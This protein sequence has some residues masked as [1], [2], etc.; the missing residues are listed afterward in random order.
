MCSRYSSYFAPPVRPGFSTWRV[1]G[2]K[3]TPT[4]PLPRLALP[5]WLQ[6][7]GWDQHDPRRTRVRQHPQRRLPPEKAGRHQPPAVHVGRRE[8]GA[9]PAPAQESLPDVEWVVAVVGQQEWVVQA[10]PGAARGKKTET[11]HHASRRHTKHTCKRA[12]ALFFVGSGEEAGQARDAF[13]Q[14]CARSRSTG[15]W[16]NPSFSSTRDRP[17]LEADGRVGEGGAAATSSVAHT[18]H[19]HRLA[20]ICDVAPLRSLKGCR[21][22]RACMPCFAQP[23]GAAAYG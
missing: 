12:R 11:A 9:H 21:R 3:N 8:P 18:A 5:P 4:E 19:P 17:V 6:Q 2:V 10:V 22:R 7:R 20:N 1:Y 23:G 15:W 13:P 16:H 14:T